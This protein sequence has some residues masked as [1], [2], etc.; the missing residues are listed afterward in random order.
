MLEFSAMRKDSRLTFRVGS[1]LKKEIETIANQ[2]GRSI[3]QICDAFLR[4][5]S[6]LYKKEGSKFLRR[7]IVRQK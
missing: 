7:F 5:A 3:A 6:E 2:E 4:A 1:D